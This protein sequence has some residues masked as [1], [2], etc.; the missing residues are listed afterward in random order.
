MKTK[1]RLRWASV[2]GAFALP[3]VTPLQAALP[4]I[5]VGA[6]A[7]M[8]QQLAML[9]DQLTTARN[10]LREAQSQLQ[11]MTG[12]RGLEN[13]LPAEPRNYLPADW[14]ELSDVFTSTSRQYQGLVASLD[15]IVQANAVLD[16]NAVARLPAAQRQALDLAR[17]EVALAQSVSRD[18]LTVTSE[19]FN[20]L[21]QLI[22]ALS[23]AQ[24]P[25]T[26][27]DL[28]ARIAAEQAM[29]TNEQAKLATMF[30][31]MRAD[32]AARRQQRRET[33]LRDIG[34]LRNLPPLGL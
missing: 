21:G 18:S 20:S 10:Q 26:V 5:D 13:L 28:Q 23:R 11:S 8:L 22:A 33:A 25:K 16:A 30:E 9:R 1:L 2:I 24:D 6:I 14:R 3:F 17:R 34:R 15:S 31:S 7:Q 12:G 4:V 29:L 27:W 32:Q 19:R